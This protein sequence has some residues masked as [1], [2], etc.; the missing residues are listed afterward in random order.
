MVFH[1]LQKYKMVVTH[2]T[3]CIVNPCTKFPIF[4]FLVTSLQ[5]FFLPF[6][7]LRLSLELYLDKT[8][9]R[10]FFLIH[11]QRC[12]FL[13]HLPPSVFTETYTL[14]RFSPVVSRTRMTGRKSKREEGGRVKSFLAACSIS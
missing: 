10:V 2:L 3:F 14:W 6:N 8:F 13:I 11:F 5:H 7:P 1:I 4:P 12:P 9:H